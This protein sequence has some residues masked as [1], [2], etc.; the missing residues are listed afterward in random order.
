MLAA[1]AA[2]AA[3]AA[4]LVWQGGAPETAGAVA[5]ATGNSACVALVI[6]RGTG[7]AT[8]APC[9]SARVLLAAQSDP[10]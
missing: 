2:I 10:R 1:G 4:A 7:L 9:A 5:A 6:D 8:Q 3:A